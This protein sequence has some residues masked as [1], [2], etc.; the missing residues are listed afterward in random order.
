MNFYLKFVATAAF[1]AI[2]YGAAVP[3]MVSARDTMLNIG[4]VALAVL[5][6][7][8]IVLMI[9]WMW[10][11]K[12]VQKLLAAAGKALPIMALL[13]IT[14]T[15]GGCVWEYHAVPAG[16]VL[17]VVNK[18]GSGKGV[19]ETEVRGP[20]R[21]WL[22]YNQEGHLFKT[23]TQT[24]TWTK[25][26]EEGDCTD[27]SINFQADKGVTVNADVGMSFSIIPNK[28]GTVFEKW[29]GSITE[30]TDVY[31]RRMTQDAFVHHAAGMAVE[32][33][34]GQAK[35]DL[36]SA[37]EKDLR[38]RVGPLGINVEDVYLVSPAR[39]PQEVTDALN[40]SIKATQVAVQRE[41]EVKESEAKAKKVEA[42]AQGEANAILKRAQ[43]QAQANELLA[44]SLSAEL[45]NYTALEKWA[46]GCTSMCSGDTS[47]FVPFVN[48][49]RK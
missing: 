30:I 8:I 49:P 9:A 26:C 33:I 14:P 12:G 46:G 19:D 40:A 39:P 45:V 21:Y 35:N 36:M 48:A 37:V 4:A 17:V 11:D 29:R 5:A 20:G 10:R 24:V 47:G 15:L 16:H 32:A 44:K 13:A 3:A 25:E 42:E 34:M 2:T 22:G 38:E 23:S 7:P 1:A 31:L 41:N 28:A 18:Y 43:A 6:A 27:E